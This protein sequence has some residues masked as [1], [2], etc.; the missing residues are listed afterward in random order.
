MLLCDCFGVT[1]LSRQNLRNI[2]LDI[3]KALDELVGRILGG[4]VRVVAHRP[5]AVLITTEP[6]LLQS[7]HPT[8]A[9][10]SEGV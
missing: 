5:N 3:Y 9:N 1:Q 10:F 7:R 4:L 8:Q 6:T 2:Q